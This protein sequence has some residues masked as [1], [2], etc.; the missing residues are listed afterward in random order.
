MALR[1]SKEEENHELFTFKLQNLFDGRYV[2]KDGDYK[3]VKT[4]VIGLAGLILSGVVTAALAWL[5]H[6]PK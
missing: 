2:L 3:L 4:L 5:L 1:E 6:A